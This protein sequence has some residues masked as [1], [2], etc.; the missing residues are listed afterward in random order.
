MTEYDSVLIFN[1]HVIGIYKNGIFI[2]KKSKGYPK[3]CL[4]HNGEQQKQLSQVLN[5]KFSIFG[6]SVIAL[7]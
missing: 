3:T 6:I 1:F 4:N 7:S 5:F 2:N